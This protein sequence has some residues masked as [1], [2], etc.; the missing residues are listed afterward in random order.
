M[1]TPESIWIRDISKWAAEVAPRPC[2]AATSFCRR[3]G[4]KVGWMRNLCWRWRMGCGCWTAPW[5]SR[6]LQDVGG[7][8]VWDYWLP[9]VKPLG[10]DG[11]GSI[12][13]CSDIARNPNMQSMPSIEYGTA[14]L[15]RV[16][17]MPMLISTYCWLLVLVLPAV[18]TD[19]I[20][21]GS[22]QCT[23]A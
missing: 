9:V 11:G 10:V 19:G 21:S 13:T 8:W 7:M 5:L 3:N 16:G 4:V 20:V 18:A 1:F 15:H 22:L 12:N 17:D 6:H 2:A 23:Y 14:D